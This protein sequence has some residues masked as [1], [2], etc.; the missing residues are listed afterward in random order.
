MYSIPKKIAMI[1]DIAGYGR[2]S[3]AVSLPVM[4]AMKVQ[5]CPVITSVFSNHTGYPVY[6]FQ[7]CTEQMTPYLDAWKELN[8][9]FDAILCGFLG[10]VRQ[11]EI[12]SRFIEKQKNKSLIIVD[13]VLG[14]HGKAYR[15]ISKE[16]CEQMKELVK[17]A[18]LITPNLTEA[19]ILS[20]TPY[21]EENWDEASM[22]EL[23]YKLHALGP[24]RIVITGIHRQNT[25]TNYILDTHASM[26]QSFY[27]VSDSIA[28]ESRHGTGDIF[29]S[30]IA[31]D[32]VNGVS[33][34][35]SVLKAA[36]FISLCINASQQALVPLQEGVIFENY[37]DF[38]WNYDSRNNIS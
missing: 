13:P 36:R 35:D 27:T 3:T 18:D 8:L 14:D 5:V 17:L 26:E 11:I 1:N 4:S 15:T 37:L 30:I 24:T 16:H 6:H 10:S 23:L 21:T 38:L 2:C 19:C 25:I 32:A 22:K 7:D 9:T 29:A 34:T 28:G 31:A 20:Q 12:V 33:F